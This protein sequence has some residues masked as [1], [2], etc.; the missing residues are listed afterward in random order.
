M[1]RFNIFLIFAFILFNFCSFSCQSSCFAYSDTNKSYFTVYDENNKLLF[2]KGDDVNE[3]D[4][5]L[6]KDN[7]LYEII[8]TGGRFFD[9]DRRICK[10]YSRQAPK[11]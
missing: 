7:K 9:I 11:N 8:L 5:Y 10:R 6:S 2:L 1:K 3:G 4:N